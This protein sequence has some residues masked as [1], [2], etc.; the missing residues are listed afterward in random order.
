MTLS[1]RD[2][3]VHVIRIAAP[4]DALPRF[5][6]LLSEEE[7]ARARRFRREPLR[8]AFLITH[9]VARMLLARY[10]GVEPAALRFAYGA[11]GKP[12]IDASRAPDFSL[13]HSGD[14]ALLAVTHGCELGVD[15]ERIRRFD[16][17][18]SVAARFFCAEETLG[19]GALPAAARELAFFRCWT[20]KEAYLKAVGDGLA[21]PLDRVRV[22][23]EAGAGAR[24]VAIDDDPAA[25]QEWTLHDM[26]PAPGYAGALAYNDRVRPMRVLPVVEPSTLCAQT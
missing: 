8:R 9:G 24:F 3:F 14:I 6:A 18:A 11:N 10:A 1:G 22:T 19:L 25:A 17:L 5:A 12:R 16:E 15:V 26:A 7:S 13:A 23:L 21:A 2:V 20:R 4:D